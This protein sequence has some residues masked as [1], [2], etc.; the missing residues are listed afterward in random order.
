MS[1]S[2]KFIKWLLL[3][4]VCTTAMLFLSYEFNDR[5][6]SLPVAGKYMQYATHKGNYLVIAYQYGDGLVRR[7]V[8]ARTYASANKDDIHEVVLSPSEVKRDVFDY[9]FIAMSILV[10]LY[11]VYWVYT[12]FYGKNKT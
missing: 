5:T 4:A 6:V 3:L 8:I 7:P 9:Y 1:I 2:L 11:Y 12:F 10:I